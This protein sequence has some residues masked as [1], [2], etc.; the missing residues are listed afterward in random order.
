M[1]VF[2]ELCRISVERV[3]LGA[4][5]RRI[6]SEKIPCFLVFPRGRGVEFSV[7]REDFGKVVAL[8]QDLDYNYVIKKESGLVSSLKKVIKRPGLLLGLL[9]V[10]VTAALYSGI[11]TDVCVGPS[12]RKDEVLACMENCGVTEGKYLP[13]VDCSALSAALLSLEGVSFASVERK[14]N[15]LYVVL[16]E[17]E[18]PP[19]Y[20]YLS[21][22]AALCSHKHAVVS[23]VLVFEGTA[24]VAVG[25]VVEVGTPLIEGYRVFGEQKVPCA[26]AGEVYGRVEYRSSVE[27]ARDDMAEHYRIIAA[28]SAKAKIPDNAVFIDARYEETENGDS[29]TVT[30][31]WTVEEK[32]TE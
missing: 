20:E 21:D 7:F 16:H 27:F 18:E 11:V 14:G 26:A 22:G 1:F 10:V 24:A 30:A 13:S 17:E 3:K 2:R 31:I 9:A 25:S 15:A 19:H 32:L 28:E 5:L 4:L 29:V 23:R 6:H 12:Y 8:L